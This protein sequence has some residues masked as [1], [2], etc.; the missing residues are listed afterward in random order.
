[1]IRRLAVAAL[2]GSSV[3]AFSTAPAH[4][5]PIC[6]ADYACTM[7]FYSNGSHTTV[8]GQIYVDCYGQRSQWGSIS[9]YE[10]VTQS[11]CSEPPAFA[12]R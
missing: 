10:V 2:L 7:T 9:G 1:M 5:V 6:K 11:E 4:A 3:F 12:T 8:I